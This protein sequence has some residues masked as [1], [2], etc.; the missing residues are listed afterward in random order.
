MEQIYIILGKAGSGKTYN[1]FKMA[2]KVYRT[3]GNNAYVLS[4]AEPIKSFLGLF[5]I[6]N[7]MDIVKID[8]NRC[9][10]K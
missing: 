9:D 1:A 8:Y 4:F 10:C 5:G 6:R 7:P 2:E 3:Q